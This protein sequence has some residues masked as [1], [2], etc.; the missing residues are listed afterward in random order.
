MLSPLRK[1]S[2]AL[3]SSKAIAFYENCFF[4]IAVRFF[5][6]IIDRYDANVL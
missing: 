3:A 1:N 5:T 4:K 6:K 2:I